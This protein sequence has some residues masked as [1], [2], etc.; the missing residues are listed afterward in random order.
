MMTASP[1]IRCKRVYLPA[2][3]DDG[4]R[5][6]VERLWPR[7]VSKDAAAIDHWLKD[8][9]PS[10]ELRRWYGHDVARWE[11][12]RRRY[13]EELAANDAVDRLLEWAR[14]SNLTLVY[15]ARDEP[16]NSAQVLHAYLSDLLSR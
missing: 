11:D 15:A 10:A 14:N 7:G 1:V 5:V 8:V 4:L 16:G 6:L 9:A 3:S 12:F 2:A 13:T